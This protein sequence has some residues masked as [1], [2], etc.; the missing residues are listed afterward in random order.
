MP[1]GPTIPDHPRLELDPTMSPDEQINALSEHFIQLKNINSTLRDQLADIQERSASLRQQVNELEEEN[2][3]L[4]RAP[5]YIA[6]VEEVFDD[7]LIIRQHGSNQE[8]VTDLPRKLAETIEP[9]SRVAINDSFGLEKHLADEIDSRARGMEIIDDPAVTYDDIGGL[10]SQIREVR[11]AVELPL[12]EPETFE[13]VGVVPPSGVLLHGPPG[14]GK[15]MLA[16]AAANRTDATF[17][18]MAGSELV[19]KFIGEGARLVRDLFRF[20]SERTPAIVFIDEVDAIATARVDSKTAGD[21]EVQRTMMQ[22]LAELDGFGSRDGIRILAATNRF[23]MLDRAIL[24][25]GRFD[26]L[27]EVPLPDE[28][29]RTRILTIHTRRMQVDDGVE[30]DT[31]A[32]EMDGASG[33]DIKATCTE[34]GM[35]AIRDERTTVTTADFIAAYEKVRS[36]DG[37]GFPVSPGVY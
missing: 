4:K 7:E 36:G 20:A 8:V 13:T 26:R 19:Q 33:A 25:P 21:A 14:T 17:I 22:L 10:D 32:A 37:P 31:L 29:A 9:G 12:R 27:I 35:F 18:R 3:A 1:N 16:K 15:T 6:T 5:T 24:R 34:A 23:D 11:E 30:F 2:A 28:D